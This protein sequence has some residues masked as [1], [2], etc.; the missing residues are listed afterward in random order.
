MNIAQNMLELVGATPLV[1]LNRLAAGLDAVVAAKVESAN[2]CFSVK[3]RIARNMI[4]DAER[5][6][7]LDPDT[8]V[9]EPTSGNTGIGMAFVC[10]VRGYKLVLTMPESMSQER[11]ALLKGF[12]AR[13]VL[14]EARLGM[15]GAID[16]AREIVAGLP[17]AFMPMQFE[18]PANPEAHRLTT[19]EEL[20]AD[21]DGG[22]DVFVAGVG[23]GGTITGVAQALK[24]R[25]A[26][27]RVVAVEP[28]ASPV[29]S[30]GAP[31]PHMIQGIGAG[32]APQVLDMA[33]V[34]QVVRVTNEDALAT[35]R[36]LLREEGIL[37]G[38]SSGANCHAALELAKQPE[39][40]GKLIVFIVCDTG[41]RY[42][43]T[44]LFTAMEEPS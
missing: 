13:L 42:L 18:N 21:T 17:K 23:T 31:G 9:V 35:A 25:K 2:P 7:L 11:R 29:L 1:R 37:C 16:R 41:E 32:F 30:G 34:D 19:A 39:N 3:D 28:D 4:L 14:T 33:L 10:A 22:L 26:G 38:I 44:A 36:R 15:K 40:K 6:G 43:S 27:L 8:V 5:R 24:P 20:W 12:G